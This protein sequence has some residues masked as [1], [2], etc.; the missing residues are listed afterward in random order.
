L[1]RSWLRRLRA[2]GVDIYPRQRW[3]G[4]NESGA[5]QFEGV[6]GTQSINADAV[7]FALGGG[8]WARLG[9][10]G[11]WVPTL[12]A[13][14]VNVAPLLPANCG[15]D[16][17]WSLYFIDHFAGQPL[18]SIAMGVADD[19]GVVNYR[20]GEA[21]ITRHGIE[22]SLVYALSA[23]LRDVIQR[24]GATTVWIDL[25][26]DRETARIAAALARP[27]GSKSLGGCNNRVENPGVW[28]LAKII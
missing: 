27:R 19:N 20:R 2:Q 21:V 4:W 6:T 25:A 23:G 16:T 8:S 13:R 18:K 28:L 15:F 12:T 24:D 22:G 14:A 26:P 11:A 1:L 3:L 17:R 5:L 10:D 9:S 7:V